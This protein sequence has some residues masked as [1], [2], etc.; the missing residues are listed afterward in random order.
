MNRESEQLSVGSDVS[1]ASVSTESTVSSTA[2]SQPASTGGLPSAVP[3]IVA[4][5]AAE[6]FSFYGMSA[7]LMVYLS[8]STY[9]NMQENE[10]AGWIHLFRGSVYFFPLLGALLADIFFGKFRIM[11]WLSLVYCLGHLALALPDCFQS[12]DPH[13]FLFLGLALIA[14]GSGGIKSCTSAIVGDQFTAEN[15]HHLNRVYHWFYLAI[16]FGSFFSMLLTPWLLK[17]CGPGWAFGVPGIL[18]ACATLILWLGRKKYR[19]VKPVGWKILDDLKNRECLGTLGRISI[20]FGFLIL[21]WAVYDQTA[22]IWVK[23]AQGMN[24]QIFAPLTFLPESIRSFELL[25]SQLQALNPL[26]ILILI[27]IFTYWIYPVWHRVWGHSTL[28]KIA[29]GLFLTVIAQCFPLAFELAAGRGIVLN[30]AWQIPAYLILT[31]AEVLVSVTALE[32]AY[33][34]SP[35][36]MKSIVMGAFL[37]TTTCGNFF[38]A[39]VNFLCERH[40][41][42]LSGSAYGLFFLILA[43]INA[44]LFLLVVRFYREKTILQEEE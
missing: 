43:L 38:V 20:V 26:L 12:C 34:Q 3:Y 24:A 4:N 1:G 36:S 22:T 31:T 17:H 10:A 39:G 29:V 42:F 23:Q 9:L 25:P 6:R 33:T 5:E 7:I 37:L 27:P 8:G 28:K 40:E 16:N 2:S 30:L 35:R 15:Q 44:L 14:L 13:T 19:I 41:G 11:F 18:M 21:F 32:F